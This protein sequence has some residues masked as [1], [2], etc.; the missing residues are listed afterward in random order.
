[1]NAEMTKL[2][3]V[4]KSCGTASKVVKVLSIIF[5]VIMIMCFVGAAIL[6]FMRNTINTE[7]A[8]NPEYMD[9]VS[10]SVNVG[11]LDFTDTVVTMM[12]NGNYAEAFGTLCIIGGLVLVFAV[13]ILKMIGRIFYLV[14]ENDSPFCDDVIVALKRVFILITVLVF[15]DSGLGTA[16]MAGI[17]FWSIYT[18]F[19]YGAELQKQADE[20]L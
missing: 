19:Q 16:V 14:L 13:V 18:I 11:Q 6:F 10:V 17:L 4:R 3:N 12:S 5:R 15:F 7:I 1:M 9:N 20:T 2:E 8:N